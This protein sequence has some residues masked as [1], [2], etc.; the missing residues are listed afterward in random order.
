MSSRYNEVRS[1]NGRKILLDWLQ[2]LIYDV[3]DALE[4]QRHAAY[5]EDEENVHFIQTRPQIRVRYV[6]RAA[7]NLSVC[8]HGT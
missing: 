6:S 1:V 2:C 4:G 7:W 5:T 8:L 3:L